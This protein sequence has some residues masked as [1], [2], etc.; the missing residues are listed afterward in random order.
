MQNNFYT[1]LFS[2]IFFWYH[3]VSGS[4][5]KPIET[6]LTY[7]IMSHNKLTNVTRD[8]FGNM[9]HLQWLD[10]TFNDLKEVDFDAFRHTR[11]LQVSTFFV[12][13]QHAQLES[14][15][16]CISQCQQALNSPLV[17]I[18]RSSICST[19]T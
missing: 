6:A 8:A 9:P 16:G 1:L 19:M 14:R 4:F 3:Q 11:R 12:T 18:S 5:F 2:D 17:T 10:L 13:M 7:L 15:A